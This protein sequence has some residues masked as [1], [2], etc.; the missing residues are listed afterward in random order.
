MRSPFNQSRSNPFGS[1]RKAT[2]EAPAQRRHDFETVLCKAI[3]AKV[4][5]T[6]AYKNDGITRTFQ[7]GA[8]YNTTTGKVCVSGVQ[9]TNPVKPAD[10]LKSHDFEVGLINYVSPTDRAWVIGDTFDRFDKKYANGI[11]CP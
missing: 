10:N 3:A 7:P 4:L 5:V 11:I 6:L 8:V 2:T 1:S 9:I